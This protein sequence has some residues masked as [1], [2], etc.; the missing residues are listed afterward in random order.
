MRNRSTLHLRYSAMPDS[1]A[2]EIQ[3]CS[4]LELASVSCCLGSFSI[5][6]AKRDVVDRARHGNAGAVSICSAFAE[7]Q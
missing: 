2:V 4:R 7:S 3:H 6:A 1:N 5:A